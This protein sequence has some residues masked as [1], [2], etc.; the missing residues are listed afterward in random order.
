MWYSWFWPEGSINAQ[1]STFLGFRFVPRDLDS[2]RHKGPRLAAPWGFEG[3][4]KGFEAQHETPWRR[5]SRS[6]V[7]L[8]CAFCRDQA[9]NLAYKLSGDSRPRG[10]RVKST[11]LD[12]RSFSVHKSSET[13]D[14]QI[15]GANGAASWRPEMEL[16]HEPEI[17]NPCVWSHHSG[18]LIFVSIPLLL[19]PVQEVSFLPLLPLKRAHSYQIVVLDMLCFTY[20]AW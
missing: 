5:E 8:I 15:L 6:L 7:V 20:P 4:R 11:K 14:R 1:N 3:R 16:K 2:R 13:W 9:Y 17:W 19:F 10:G 12:G 18:V